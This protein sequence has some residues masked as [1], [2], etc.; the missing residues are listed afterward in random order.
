MACPKENKLVGLNAH[1]QMKIELL[2]VW[3]YSHSTIN[4]NDNF[5]S[6]N[7]D[8]APAN[9]KFRRKH[10]YEKKLLVG[11]AMSTRGISEPFIM[12]SGNAV[13]RDSCLAPRLLSFI[14]INH[15]DGNYIF[16]TY[17][18]GCHYAEHSL[19]FLCENSISIR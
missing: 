3:E 15:S 18:A 13:D 4:G 11:I 7:I 2:R 16:W 12:A 17:Q 5:Y 8:F 9:L 14:K 1:N 6:D 10:K 19:D